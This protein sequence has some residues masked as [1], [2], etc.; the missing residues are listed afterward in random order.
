M[1]GAGGPHLGVNVWT[2]QH[3]SVT[4]V[5]DLA[6]WTQTATWAESTTDQPVALVR[7]GEAR[8][9]PYDAPTQVLAAV[10]REIELLGVQ[11][12]PAAG[13]P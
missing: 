10:L 5:W 3:L 7:S 1:T 13:R 8:I 4:Q 2:S 6:L 11:E 12:P 9:H